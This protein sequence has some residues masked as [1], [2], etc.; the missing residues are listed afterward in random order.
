MNTPIIGIT[1]FS[2]GG[3]CPRSAVNQSYIDAIVTAGGAP[4]C[5]PLGLDGQGIEQIYPLLDGLLLPG[6][7]DVAP[8]EYGEERHSA[9][10]VV[11]EARDSLELTLTRHALRDDMPILGIC[12]GIQ[13]LAVA[14]GGTLYQDVPTQWGTH[15]RHEVR[16][17]GRDFLTHTIAIDSASHLGTALRCTSAR[18]NSLHHQAVRDVPPGF[19]VTAQSE[20]GLIEAIEQP[21]HRFVVGIQCHPEEIWRT[22]APE[23]AALFSAFV[24]AVRDHMAMPRE[25][26]S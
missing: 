2:L 23:F 11:D 15:V 1:C 16:E 13:L 25:E 14:A 21:D 12:R 9:L 8:D 17:F 3:D 10:G 18:V 5:I 6:G 4:L 26:A 24:Q 19:V 7:V 20:E 22:T